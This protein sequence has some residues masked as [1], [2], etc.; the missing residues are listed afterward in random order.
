MARPRRRT[1][2]AGDELE[3]AFAYKVEALLNL[4][5]WRWYHTHDSRRSA[6]GFPD[7]AAVR[8]PELIFA[9]LK[10]ERGRLR[11]AQREWLEDLGRLAGYLKI[12]STFAEREGLATALRS[13][14][15]DELAL[16]AIKSPPARDYAAVGVY[17]TLDVYIWRPSDLEAIND[18]LSRGRHRLDFVG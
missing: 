7:Y 2:V 17:P 14:A 4:Y 10:A 11:P 18:R 1:G 13:A 12:V 3:Q 16:E 6:P 9:E 15:G 8:G 5:G